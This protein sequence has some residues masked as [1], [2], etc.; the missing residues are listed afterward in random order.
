[1]HNDAGAVKTAAVL[2]LVSSPTQGSPEQKLPERP[3]DS[4]TAQTGHTAL[5]QQA[6][7]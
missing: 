7:W 6:E 1:M 4:T 2:E 5:L 3:T